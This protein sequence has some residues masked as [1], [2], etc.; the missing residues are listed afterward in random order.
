MLC[1]LCTGATALTRSTFVQG[2]GPIWLDDVRCTG[3]EARL[4]DCTASS[5]GTHNC[6]HAEEAGVR[7]MTSSKLAMIVTVPKL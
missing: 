4:L 5:V 7:C 3:T 1:I 2:T 6:G